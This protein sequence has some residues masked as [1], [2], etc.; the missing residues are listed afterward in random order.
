MRIIFARLDDDPGDW[1]E[2]YPFSEKDRKRTL[3]VFFAVG[4]PDGGNKNV[5]EGNPTE[6]M[7]QWICT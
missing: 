4:Y 6:R 1:V 5:G 7:L 3:R 2:V